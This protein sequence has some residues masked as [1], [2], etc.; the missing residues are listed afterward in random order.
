[1]EKSVKKCPTD[2]SILD[3]GVRWS[4]GDSAPISLDAPTGFRWCGESFIFIADGSVV[5]RGCDGQLDAV[6]GEFDLL[7]GFGGNGGNSGTSL[8]VVRS[9]GG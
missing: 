5:D 3:G 1:M 6:A 4:L 8:R 2:E 7:S 9:V